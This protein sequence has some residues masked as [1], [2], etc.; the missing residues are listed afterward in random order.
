MGGRTFQKRV[1]LHLC[2]QLLEWY[3]YTLFSHTSFSDILQAHVTRVHDISSERKTAENLL[4]LIREEMTLLSDDY[5]LQVIGVCTDASGESRA[6]RL[7]LLKEMPWLL[8]AD[9]W[10]HQV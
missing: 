8:V 7:R 6:A 9:C 5:H 3:E 10:A 1:S 2:L 4:G